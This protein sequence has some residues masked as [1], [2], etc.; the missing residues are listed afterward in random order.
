MGLVFLGLPG[1]LNFFLGISFFEKYIL[2]R[3]GSRNAHYFWKME[4][5]DLAKVIIGTPCNIYISE[6]LKLNIFQ[7]PPWN[8][9][10]KIGNVIFWKMVHFNPLI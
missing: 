10:Y 9:P 7:Y 8:F 1:M 5:I 6:Y 3:L 2:R 4:G